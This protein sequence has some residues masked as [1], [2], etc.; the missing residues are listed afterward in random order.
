MTKVLLGNGSRSG[1]SLIEPSSPYAEPFRNLR[2]ALGLRST[3]VSRRAVLITSP[4]VREGKSTIAA[5]LALVASLGQR[6][7]LIDADLRRSVQHEQFGLPRAPGLVELLAAPEVALDDFVQQAG[8]LEV[9]T[10]G[11]PVLRAGDL[12]SSKRMEQIIQ[13]TLERYELVVLD[14]PPVLHASDAAGLAAHSCVDV[15]LVVNGSTRRRAIR[16][17]LRELELVEATVLGV[18]ANRHG[19][20]APYY[21]YR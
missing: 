12:A 15:V 14:S 21:G 17:A 7:L 16:H 5:N 6:T 4:G 10:A 11:R 18:V 2:L 19:R 9:L 13:A 8:T 1:S 20:L 3:G